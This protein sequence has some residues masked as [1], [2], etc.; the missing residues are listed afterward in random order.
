[1]FFKEFIFNIN[2]LKWYKNILKYKKYI[3]LKYKKKTCQNFTVYIDTLSLSLSLIYLAT[4]GLFP[5]AYQICVSF[6]QD[7]PHVGCAYPH[8]FTPFLFRVQVWKLIS[9]RFFFHSL[10]FTQTQNNKMR[11]NLLPSWNQHPESHCIIFLFDNKNIFKL[12]YV[13]IENIFF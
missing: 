3:F 6:I 4:K 9:L 10:F 8:A 13:S 11:T 12:V 7:R 1:M 5:R 2:K